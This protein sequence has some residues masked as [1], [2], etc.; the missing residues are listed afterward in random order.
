MSLA[1]KLITLR[2]QKGLTQME[3]AETLNVSRQ[4]VSRWEVGIA[5]PSMD[6][7]R[8]LGKLYAVSVD[9]LLDD[10]MDANGDFKG[11]EQKNFEPG[12]SITAR[13]NRWWFLVFLSMIVLAIIIICI[14][15]RLSGY[16]EKSENRMPISDLA[17]DTVDDSTVTFQFEWGSN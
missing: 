6:N 13:K 17:T 16:G 8:T 15:L 1:E 10:T 3:L 14:H 2:K 9:S 5:M 4:A 7:L 12:A 11:E